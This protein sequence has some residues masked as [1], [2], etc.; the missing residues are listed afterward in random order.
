MAS[1]PERPLAASEETPH[2]NEKPDSES[3]DTD[4]PVEDKPAADIDDLPVRSSARISSSSALASRRNRTAIACVGCVSAVVLG[5]LAA[6]LMFAVSTKNGTLPEPL[7]QG[8][9]ARCSDQMQRLTDALHR[10]RNKND[11]YPQQLQ[12]LWP[13][14]LTDQSI[15]WCPADDARKGP[16]SYHYIRP[17]P[18]APDSDIVLKCDFHSTARSRLTLAA[19]LGG[20]ILHLRETDPSLR[21][22]AKRGEK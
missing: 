2:T 18:D 6:I 1:E 3:A 21:Q 5:M 22:P 14:F 12:D 13:D 10:Y 15:L 19:T 17:S 16:T 20:E 4:S 9:I 11:V 8:E 7:R